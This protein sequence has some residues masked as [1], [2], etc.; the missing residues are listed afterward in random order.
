[1]PQDSYGYSLN[2]SFSFL[3][4]LRC[5]ALCDIFPQVLLDNGVS[6]DELKLY[7]DIEDDD[8]LSDFAELEEVISK[9][10]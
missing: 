5:R 8:T 3:L 7:G 4:K 6:V 1:M 10:C 9:V 2:C